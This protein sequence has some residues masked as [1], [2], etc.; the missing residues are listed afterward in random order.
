MCEAAVTKTLTRA[1]H[2]SFIIKVVMS[3]TR[4]IAR[5][6]CIPIQLYIQFRC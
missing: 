3:K 4:V 1:D 6:D 5:L 2:K